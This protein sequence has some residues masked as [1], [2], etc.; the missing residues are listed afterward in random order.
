M[1]YDSWNI[2]CDRQKFL[3]FWTL[4]YP[5]S[6]LATWRI[7]TFR[8]K[9]TTGDTIILYICTINDNHMMYGSW[10]ME[11]IRQFFVILDR[12]LPFGQRKS[13]FSKN[14]K[15]T[16]RYYHFANVYHKWQLYEVWFLR[17]VAWWTELFV[18]LDHFLHFYTLNNPQ[19][20]KILKKKKLPWG[21]IILHMCARKWF[22]RYEA[23]QTKFLVILDQFLHFNPA[24]NPKTKTFEKK[25]KK[26]WKYG[27]FRQVYQTP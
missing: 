11:C 9:K 25:K 22:L 19:K 16:W 12:F 20:S 1:I 24:N 2:K 8:L 15:N 4:F 6:S 10:D 14:E 23:W 5:F 21:I 18:F 27:H 3:S 13:K 17:Y 7:K 26:H